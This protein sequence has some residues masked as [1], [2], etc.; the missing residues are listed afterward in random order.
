MKRKQGS[1]QNVSWTIYYTRST[2]TCIWSL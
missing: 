2:C 1:T